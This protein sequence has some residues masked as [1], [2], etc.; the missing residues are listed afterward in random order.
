MFSARAS[1]LYFRLVQGLQ[2]RK[3]C[4]LRVS[5]CLDIPNQGRKGMFCACHRPREPTAV[6][7]VTL[8]CNQIRQFCNLIRSVS[9]VLT[10]KYHCFF[11]F[12]K[13]SIFFSS[14]LLFKARPFFMG[15]QDHLLKL[16]FYPLP[17]SQLSPG[18]VFA[19]SARP[20]ADSK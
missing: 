2:S 8:L 7:I 4:V 18:K 15:A 12:T 19:A 10:I 16:I 3:S 5:G 9:S 1:N 11:I 20:T 13:S 17:P 6:K 14:L